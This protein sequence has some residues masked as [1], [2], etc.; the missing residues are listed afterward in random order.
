MK[1]LLLKSLF[2][3]M[4]AIGGLTPVLP[5][6]AFCLSCVWSGPCMGNFVCGSRCICVKRSIIDVSGFCAVRY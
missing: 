3:V 6:E 4:L 1:R 5:N 2:V